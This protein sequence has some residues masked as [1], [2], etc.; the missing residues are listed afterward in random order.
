VTKT[1]T[2]W[3]EKLYTFE[4][5]RECINAFLA[6]SMLDFVTHKSFMAW[7]FFHLTKYS[8]SCPFKCL[9]RSTPSP[10]ILI[11]INDTLWR[12]QL[13][14]LLWPLGILGKWLQK[15]EIGRLSEFLKIVWNFNW[16]HSSTWLGL[17]LFGLLV[18]GGWIEML[19]F[20]EQN[21]P[22]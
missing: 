7:Y 9:N 6:W 22:R 10:H 13:M 19:T 21:P 3:V 16:W 2:Y 11:I 1:Y 5:I 4:G 17:F 8:H 14:T 12:S 20:C 18:L 15:W